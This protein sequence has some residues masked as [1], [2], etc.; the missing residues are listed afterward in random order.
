[1][2]IDS[3]IEMQLKSVNVSEIYYFCHRPYKFE[4]LNVSKVELFLHFMIF[5]IKFYINCPIYK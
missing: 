3:Y 2:G 5:S 1:M 4:I